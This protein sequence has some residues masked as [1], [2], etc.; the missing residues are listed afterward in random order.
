MRR[1]TSV[2]SLRLGRSTASGRASIL[3]KYSMSG[4]RSSGIYMTEKCDAASSRENSSR[5]ENTSRYG[6][7]TYPRLSLSRAYERP[8]EKERTAPVTS[9]EVS[10]MKTHSFRIYTIRATYCFSN[11]SST[12]A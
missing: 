10:N 12:S 6:S 2:D 9:P 1:R 3:E 8:I 11:S 4:F 7:S 5:P